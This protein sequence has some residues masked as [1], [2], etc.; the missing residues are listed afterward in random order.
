MQAHQS[1]ALLVAK[2][3]GMIDCNPHSINAVKKY[4]AIRRERKIK[5]ELSLD[6][7]YRALQIELEAAKA[8]IA[9]QAKELK[10]SECKGI[11]LA[12]GYNDY[13]AGILS[14]GL[15]GAK[16]V[17]SETE[18]ITALDNFEKDEMRRNSKQTRMRGEVKQSAMLTCTKEQF[19]KMTYKQKVQFAAS[20]SELYQKL[21]KQ[22]G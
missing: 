7:K 8:T 13:M 4:K 1:N 9:R 11:M 2:R 21:L 20:N 16:N 3:G 5:M 14:T 15:V 6:Q 12:R 19:D 10:I 17:T 22:R 18:F